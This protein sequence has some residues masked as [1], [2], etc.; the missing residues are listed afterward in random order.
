MRKLPLYSPYPVV[1]MSADRLAQI[2]LH[3]R[4]LL[5]EVHWVTCEEEGCGCPSSRKLIAARQTVV[6]LERLCDSL[7]A[8]QKENQ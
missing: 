1:Q 3:L 6:E 8:Q 4:E 7:A 5:E 2:A